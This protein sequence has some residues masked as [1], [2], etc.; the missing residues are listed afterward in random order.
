MGEH[1]NKQLLDTKQKHF[2]IRHYAEKADQ[3]TFK[4]GI[5]HLKDD[6]VQMMC[7]KCLRSLFVSKHGGVAGSA[8]KNICLNE[9][10]LENGNKSEQVAG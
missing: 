10:E 7:S 1:M 5:V 3:H 8:H 6:M 4:P 9:K 2:L